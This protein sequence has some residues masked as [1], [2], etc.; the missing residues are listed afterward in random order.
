MEAYQGFIT[1]AT[2][3]QA[4]VNFL[5]RTN[6]L[7]AQS[8]LMKMTPYGPYDL[9]RKEEMKSF[10]CDIMVLITNENLWMYWCL[11]LS[12]LDE[13]WHVSVQ[14]FSFTGY[15]DSERQL[16]P[17]FWRTIN[18]SMIDRSRLIHH[19]LLLIMSVMDSSAYIARAEEL[20]LEVEYLSHELEQSTSINGLA[21]SNPLLLFISY[22]KPECLKKLWRLPSNL[23]DIKKALPDLSDHI[24]EYLEMDNDVSIEGITPWKAHFQSCHSYYALKRAFE[25]VVFHYSDEELDDPLP[26]TFLKYVLTS[27]SD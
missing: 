6:I 14:N 23:L 3:N 2:Y 9:R 22:V 1:I 12:N 8:S 25:K 7:P 4:Y 20:Q 13:V 27:Y 19:T 5:Y 17:L 15:C 24:S 16:P 26:Y 18:V 10:L 11:A 21:L